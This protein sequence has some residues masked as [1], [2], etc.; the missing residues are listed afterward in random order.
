MVDLG[1]QQFTDHLRPPLNEPDQ[2]VSCSRDQ[3]VKIWDCTTG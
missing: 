1:V 2:V 3:S